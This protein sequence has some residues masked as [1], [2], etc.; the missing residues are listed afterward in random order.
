MNQPMPIN[1]FFFIIISCSDLIH[2]IE[3]IQKKNKKKICSKLKEEIAKK[4][5][6]LF[7]NNQKNCYNHAKW[8]Y[9]LS[10]KTFA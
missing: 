9:I 10:C 3:I 2:S 6:T 8:F 5:Y 4:I 1:N 7:K